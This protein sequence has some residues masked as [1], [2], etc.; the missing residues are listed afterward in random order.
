MRID[1]SI[2]Q[3]FMKE[4]SRMCKY[5]SSCKKCDMNFVGEFG[6]TGYEDCM[7]TLQCEGHM[8]NIQKIVQNWSD[9]HPQKT[10]LSD[11][12]EKYPNGKLSSM[13]LPYELC[14]DRFG[15]EEKSDCFDGFGHCSKCWNKPME[16]GEK[17][18]D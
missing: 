9:E 7:S 5:V 8:S 13:G 4:F 11:F 6:T 10:F 14:P 15:Y 3:N 17:N 16:Q 2:T 1:C 18:E 12:L